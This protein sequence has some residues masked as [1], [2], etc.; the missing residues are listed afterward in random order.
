MGAEYGWWCYWRLCKGCI[1]SAAVCVAMCLCTVSITTNWENML[2][3]ATGWTQ[4]SSSLASTGKQFSNLCCLGGSDRLGF[5]EV[6]KHTQQKLIWRKLKKKTNTPER[7]VQNC[8]TVHAVIYGCMYTT[9]TIQ[10]YTILHII[11][12]AIDWKMVKEENKSIYSCMAC[13]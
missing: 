2:S 9:Y 8:R 4:S 10:Q 13:F 12:S 11:I 5:Q 6:K 3:L 7:H 1:I